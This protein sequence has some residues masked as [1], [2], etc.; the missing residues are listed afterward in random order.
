MGD[1]Y[2]QVKNYV[3]NSH[4]GIVLE[5]GS[6]RYEGSSAYFAE[7]AKQLGTQFIT[8]DL[9]ENM[10]RRLAQCIPAYLKPITE[11]IHCDGTEWTKTCKHQISVLY[12]DNF[13]WDWEVG[14]Q[15]KMI[16]EQR[17]WYRERGIEM[18]NVNCQ[19]AHLTQMQN[20]LPHMTDNCVVCLDDTYLHNG[21]YIGKGGAVVPYLLVN[22]FEILLTQ[23]YGVIMGRTK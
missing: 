6:D 23:D 12:L 5:I 13:D 14:T 4:S 8:L 18:N 17:A 20:L 16:K 21:V 2:K 22:G 1:C 15:D 10:P 11:F 9:D 19:V 3:N 7:I